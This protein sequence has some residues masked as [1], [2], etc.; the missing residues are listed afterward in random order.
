MSVMLIKAAGVC[1]WPAEHV[2]V[3][4]L[5]CHFPVS[6]KSREA[7]PSAPVRLG[8]WR[9]E[10]GLTLVMVMSAAVT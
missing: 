6:S 10:Q 5:S 9:P 8:M 2:S 4:S 7:G 1:K 3:P